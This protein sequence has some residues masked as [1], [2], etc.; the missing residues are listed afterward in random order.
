[1][2]VKVIPAM[3][4]DRLAPARFSP[5][6]DKGK[7]VPRTPEVTGNIDYTGSGNYASFPG[8]AENIA[9][10]IVMIGRCFTSSSDNANDP[11]EIIVDIG[12]AR[13]L[14]PWHT[15]RTMPRRWTQ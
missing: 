2:F 15:Q 5:A 1:M 8:D 10:R 6:I 14:R 12:N 7:E 9:D 4:V 13:L 11:T 3:P